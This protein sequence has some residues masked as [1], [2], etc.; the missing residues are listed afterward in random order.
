VTSGLLE[1]TTHAVR[2]STTATAIARFG[3]VARAAF[4]LLLAYLVVRVMLADP[5]P[6]A[7]AS[8]ALRTVASTPLGRL[9]IALAAVGFLGFGISRLLGALRDRDATMTSR[10]TTGLQGLFY[11]ALTEVPASFAL[12]SSSTGSEQ[13]QRTTTERLMALP[14]GRA[15]VVALG[16][17]VIVVC[18]WQAV[19]AARTGFTDSMRTGDAP[20]WV[21][22]LVRVTG[23]LG[24]VMR[25]VVFLPI[26]VFLVVA[27]V[28]YDPAKAK[29][30]DATLSTVAH[31]PWGRGVL[32]L[33]AA[34]FVVFAVYS[35][36]EARYRDVDAG[37]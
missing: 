17:V 4:Y 13:Q 3:L 29:G 30:L 20:H 33:I 12:G 9:P 23:R 15:I 21:Q 31:H 8:G 34:G 14:A 6:Q 2:D 10:L 16:V 24:I 11:I 25:A 1:R 36:L 7:N 22:V 26:G 37:D 35:M 5:G 32:G 18:L 27:A 19:T 28:R